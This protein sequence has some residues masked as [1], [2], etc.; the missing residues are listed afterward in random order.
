[1]AG[2]IAGAV[3]ENAGAAAENGF[4]LRPGRVG[5]REA[6]RKVVH[7]VVEI[8]LEVVAH[9][10]SDGEIRFDP[11]AVFHKTGDDAFPE[12]DVSI[13]GLDSETGGLVCIERVDVGE[14]VGALLVRKVVVT[15][16]AEIRDVDAKSQ[17]VAA[18]GVSNKV[19]SIEV[20]F[21]TVEIGLRAAARE[22]ALNDHLGSGNVARGRLIVVSEEETKLVY[23][24]R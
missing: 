18:A 17:H 22:I 7:V 12:N 15:T 3:I 10:E 6:G 23:P 19:G 21:R 9:A 2:A 14:S 5:E 1:M 4:A 13:A 8:V 20:G 24:L 11:H 16:A